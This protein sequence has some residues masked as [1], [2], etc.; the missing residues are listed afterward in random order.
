MTPALRM[1][2]SDS[3]RGV[4]ITPSNTGSVVFVAF[5]PLVALVNGVGAGSGGGVGAGVPGTTGW[6]V[7]AGA[8]VSL[9]IC[10]TAD[11]ASNTRSDGSTTP[12]G[13]RMISYQ[14]LHTRWHHHNRNVNQS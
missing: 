14:I 10:P 11:A 12:V 4:T 7:V 6:S 9:A 13:Q 3:V 2:A 5:V 8:T 1:S